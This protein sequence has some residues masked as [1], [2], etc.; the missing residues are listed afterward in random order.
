MAYKEL[1][2]LSVDQAFIKARSFIKNNEF[3]EAKKLYQ[4]ILLAFPKNIRAQKELNTLNKYQQT[5]VSQS[6]LQEK[7]DHLVNIYNQ[8]Q[9][10]AV[11][12]QAQSLTMQYPNAYMIWN[13]LG[14]GRKGLGQIE[15]ASEAFKRVTE[16]NPNYADGFNNLG[17]TLQIL[18]KYEEAVEAYN[19]SLSIKPHY[20]DAFINLGTALNEQG[21]LDES[22]VA[23]S[24]ALLINPNYAEAHFNL[25][26]I[27]KVQ[28]K[29]EEAIKSYNKALSFKPNYPETYYNIGNVLRD[30]GKFDQAVE[31]YKKSLF[32]NPKNPNVFINLGVALREQDKYEEAIEAYDKAL[33]LKP[34]YAEAYHNKGLVFAINGKSDEALKAYNKARL[35]KPDYADPNVYMSFLH[36]KNGKLKEG[37]DQYEWRWKTKNGLNRQR[38]FRQ[39]LWDG[40]ESLKDKRILIW[41]EQGIGDTINWSSLVSHV[42]SQAQHCILECQGKLV[43]LLQRSFPN[44]EVKH[45]NR[46]FDLE[47][48]DFDFHLP[49]GSIYKHCIE[50]ISGNSNVKS[51]LIPNPVRVN[52]W[53][54]RLQYLGNGPYIGISWKSS[55]MSSER[56]LN[57]SSIEEWFPILKIPNV[58]FINLQNKDFE[59]DLIKIQDEF[60]VKVHN[61]DD[62]DHFDDI[63]DV[64]ALCSALDMIISNKTT[65]PFIS[66]GVG[67]ST[68][69]ANWRQSQWNNIL[70]N[71]M[72]SSVKIYERNTWEPWDNVFNSIAKDIFAITKI[73]S[74]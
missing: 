69:L 73:W 63:D 24:K 9:L 15:E 58:N 12:E 1:T 21:K 57:Y 66:G 32:L 64:A 4:T 71:P 74:S 30:L 7:I 37:L 2:K 36:L 13:I 48:E 23:F 14:A 43:S 60:G 55:N 44:V 56:I 31:T 10:A 3:T 45:A 34:D 42:S 41:S 67:T 51:H 61:F 70:L 35:L 6:L 26:N 52:F 40:K 17:V 38:H 27:L 20:A 47:R 59:D 29:Y 22:I 39:P 65:L 19:K 33:S 8:G 5:N 18:G 50:D 54:K 53:K 62:I 28:G 46:S 25:G 16:L 11:I 72:S 49:M 68:K